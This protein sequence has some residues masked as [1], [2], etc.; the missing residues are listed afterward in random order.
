MPATRSRPARVDWRDP[1]VMEI[2]EV[3]FGMTA[4]F[5]SFYIESAIGRLQNGKYAPL[6]IFDG[7]FRAPNGV[8]Q[9]LDDQADRVNLDLLGRIDHNRILLSLSLG[10]SGNT[11]VKAP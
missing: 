6:A 11:L 7:A 10:A 1:A 4:M 9:W 8:R 3:V 2:T 5:D